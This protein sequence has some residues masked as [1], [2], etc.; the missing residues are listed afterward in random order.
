MGMDSC[1]SPRDRISF[2]FPP[3]MQTSHLPVTRRRHE[4]RR[5]TLTPV[6]VCHPDPASTRDGAFPLSDRSMTEL[7]CSFLR[8][9]SDC[10]RGTAVDEPSR[11][12]I[13]D[14]ECA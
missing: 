3:K 14:P 13:G 11:L 4:H 1:A 12:R 6:V 10:L 5:G 2:H 9:T 8:T 7:R